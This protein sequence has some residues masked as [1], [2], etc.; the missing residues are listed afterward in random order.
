MAHLRLSRAC[1]LVRSRLREEAGYTLFELS[2]GPRDHGRR[3][4]RADDV[5]RRR[6]E[7]RGGDD[8]PRAGA[9]ERQARS[10]PDADRHPLCERRAGTTGEPVRRVHVDPDRVAQRLP[11][12]DD[13][14]VGCAV[15]HD[16]VH[17]FDDALAALP[18]PGDAALRLRRRWSLDAARGLRH[19]SR[20]RVAGEQRHV[21]D[22][23]GLGRKSLADRGAAALPAAFP[24]SRCR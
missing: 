5:V 7:R 20:E 10:R 22:P 4:Q 15:V 23:V 1:R 6:A 14:L 8:P 16:P 21:A 17:G 9:T 11:G 24:S 13:E 19:P 2:D 3:S 18:V 12:R